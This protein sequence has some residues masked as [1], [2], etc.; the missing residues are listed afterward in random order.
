MTNDADLASTQADTNEQHNTEDPTSSAPDNLADAPLPTKEPTELTTSSFPN[1]TPL[2]PLTDHTQLPTRFYAFFQLY[3]CAAIFANL[4]LLFWDSNGDVGYWVDWTKQLANNGYTNFDG[5]YPPIYIH[6]LYLVA[7]IY[8]YLELPIE[9][10]LLIKYLAQV[11]ILLAHLVL[12]AVVYKL[13]RK[14]STNS[15]HFHIAMMLTALNP[16]ILFNGP[17]WGQVDILPLLPVAA[18]LL[19]SSSCRFKLLTMPLYTLA[20]LTKF[21]MIAFAPLMGIIFLRHIKLHLVGCG[22]ALVTIVI[23]FIPFA[24]AGNF[25]GAIQLAYVDVLHQYSATTM[26]AA[27]IWILLTGNAAPDNIILFGISADSPL[28]I[29]FKAKHFGMICFT[30]VCLIVFAQG[31]YLLWKQKL[32]QQN[33][34]NAAQLFFYA[35]I[36]TMAFFTLL[37]A[38]HERYLLPAVIIAL[39][40]YALNPKLLIYPIAFS[41]ISA[42]NLAMCM[43]LKTANVWPAISWLMLGIFTYGIL[44]LLVGRR[45]FN[46]TQK[47]FWHLAEYRYFSLLVLI[48]STTYMSNRLYNESYLYK[49]TLSSNQMFLTELPMAI[50]EQ[51]YGQVNINRSVNGTILTADNRRYAVGI[52]THANSRI[53]YRLPTHTVQL[54]IMAALDDEAESASIV[55]SI[56]GDDRKLWE[57]PPHYGAEAPAEVSVD[58]TGINR[59][60]LEVDG[61]GEISSDHADWLNPVLTFQP[62]Q[63]PL[64][65]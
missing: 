9:N 7:Q 2:S 19:V 65:N 39:V 12:I 54:H 45:W 16:A 14:Y 10:N 47:Y 62:D 37:P 36:C 43:G 44:E 6:W 42:F 15:S 27:N 32:A 52:G 55:F 26:G 21:Q 29:L 56:W 28:A 57:S 58:L 22:I 25:L 5:N 59:L 23:A 64:N 63:A 53:E 4:G 34:N 31:L 41:F 48:I 30:I 13:L 11:P 61:M 24:L 8:N 46:V 49:P 18:A 40:G 50:A 1:F 38:M 3:I 33:P 20:L 17:I 51:G 60:R 35:M